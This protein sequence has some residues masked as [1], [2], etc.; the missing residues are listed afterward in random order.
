MPSHHRSVKRA[1][2]LNVCTSIWIIYSCRSLKELVPQPRM[3]AGVASTM[4]FYADRNSKTV[5]VAIQ[6]MLMGALRPQP[7]ERLMSFS[8][9]RILDAILR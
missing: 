8:G 9:G 3:A 4:Q 2:T 5:A 6:M 7:Y 1:T